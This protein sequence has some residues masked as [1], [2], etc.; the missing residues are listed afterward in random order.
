MGIL[1]R[2]KELNEVTRL[3]DQLATYHFPIGA[4]TVSL[5]IIR[6]FSRTSM[7]RLRLLRL[8]QVH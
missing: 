1:P 8:L 3:G 5:L 4:R 2:T 7:L 6:V